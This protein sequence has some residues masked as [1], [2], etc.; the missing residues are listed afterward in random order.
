MQELGRPAEVAIT[1]VL[2]KT[3]IDKVI[4]D[5]GLVVTI[6]DV[7]EV[8]GGFV[9]HSDGGAHYRVKFRVVVFRPFAEEMIVGRVSRMDE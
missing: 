9:Y 6:Y 8:D 4:T 1:A 7:L 5:L 3:F 2:E